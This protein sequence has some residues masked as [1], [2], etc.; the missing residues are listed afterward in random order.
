MTMPSHFQEY[1]SKRD[2]EEDTRYKRLVEIDRRGQQ[3]YYAT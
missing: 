2:V 3:Q 1:H